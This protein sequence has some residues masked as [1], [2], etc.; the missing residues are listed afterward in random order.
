VTGLASLVR[1]RRR[2]TRRARGR[3][4]RTR[5]RT[6][7]RRRRTRRRRGGRPVRVACCG[8]TARGTRGAGA[9]ARVAAHDA[10]TAGAQ[11]RIVAL[12]L[13]G[14]MLQASARGVDINLSIP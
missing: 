6:R 2:S 8:G 14:G 7:T 12:Q 1:M 3:R 9:V 4:M 11:H 5:T 13:N 10:R